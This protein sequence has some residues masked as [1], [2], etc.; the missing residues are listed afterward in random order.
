MSDWGDSSSEN[1]MGPTLQKDDLPETCYFKAFRRPGPNYGVRPVFY[2]IMAAKFAFILI[3]EVWHP[4]K[5][6][7]H[8]SMAPLISLTCMLICIIY[9]KHVYMQKK[10]IG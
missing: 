2:H 10:C 3:M 7:V 9:A 1:W 6:L 4:E 5:C 8:D